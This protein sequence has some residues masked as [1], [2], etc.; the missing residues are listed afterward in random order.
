LNDEG[1]VY[2]GQLKGLKDF[3]LLGT[4]VSEAGVRRFLR[5]QKTFLERYPE[6]SIKIV[7]EDGVFKGIVS[8]HGLKKMTH[9]KSQ[10]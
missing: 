7:I 4:H 1:L 5:V 8:K 3:D 10:R 2:L 9:P 6:N